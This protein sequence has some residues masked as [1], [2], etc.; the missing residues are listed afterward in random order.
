[1]RRSSICVRDRIRR[2]QW[3]PLILA[4]EYAVCFK[5]DRSL[6]RRLFWLVPALMSRLACHSGLCAYGGPSQSRA[7]CCAN[8]LV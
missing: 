7:T 6:Q 3:G 1:M 8:G 2:Q 5:K 4:C